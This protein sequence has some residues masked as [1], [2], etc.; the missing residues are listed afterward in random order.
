M[1]LG[2][3]NVRVYVSSRYYSAG[4]CLKQLFT[5]EIVVYIHALQNSELNTREK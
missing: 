5:S 3:R 2:H 4:L 1:A